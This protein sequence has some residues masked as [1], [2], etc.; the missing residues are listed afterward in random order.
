MEYR[1]LQ[2]AFMKHNK[3]KKLQISKESLRTLALARLDEVVGGINT[4]GNGATCQTCVVG[5]PSVPC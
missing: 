3:P 4:S 5:C 2:S 1:L